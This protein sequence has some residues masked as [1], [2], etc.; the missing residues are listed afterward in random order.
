MTPLA[1][2]INARR[3]VSP[4][5]I[6][7]TCAFCGRAD[8]PRAADYAAHAPEAARGEEGRGGVSRGTGRMRRPLVARCRRCAVLTRDWWQLANGDRVCAKCVTDALPR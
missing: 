7:P 3:V 5:P 6:R 4:S 8:C 1:A 2:R